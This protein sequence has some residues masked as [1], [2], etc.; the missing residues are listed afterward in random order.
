MKR[1]PNAKF[2][3]IKNKGTLQELLTQEVQQLVQF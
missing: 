1:E 2:R 3:N